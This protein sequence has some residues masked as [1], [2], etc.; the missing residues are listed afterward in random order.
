MFIDASKFPAGHVERARICIF[1]SGPAGMTLA[2]SLAK[3]EIDVLLVEAGGLEFE[4]ESQALYE[5]TVIGDEYYDLDFARLRYFGGTSGHWA[6]YCRPLDAHDFEENP[7]VPHTGWPIGRDALDPYL[8]GAAEILEIPNDFDDRELSGNLD[9]TVFHVSPPVLFGEKYLDE[10]QTSETLRVVL[11]TAVINMTPQGGRVRSA[12]VQTMRGEAWTIEADYFV[13][14]TG[15]IENSRLLLWF[16]EQNDRKLIKNHDILGRYWME[17]PTVSVGEAIIKTEDDDIFDDGQAYF[18]L[19]G[20]FQKVHGV[21]NAGF[22]LEPQAYK[23]RNELAADL[24][25]LA[26]KLS[27][28]VLG[29]ERNLVCGARIEVQ[30]EQAPDP[31]NRV[32]L[33][34]EKDALGIPRV[35]L[36]WRK[37]ALDRKTVAASTIALAEEFAK[38][39]I[40][41][42]RLFDWIDDDNLPIPIA[43]GRWMAAFHHMGGTRMSTTPASGVIDT[44]L[45]VHDLDNLYVGGSS[46]FPSVGYANP[47]LTI[48]QL[49]LRLADHL[50]GRLR[51]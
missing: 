20:A 43:A 26:P 49:S 44:D 9:R 37:S 4:A 36:Y 35:V 30:W 34:E 2:Q 7:A 15:G 27:Q 12:T 28:W 22:N 6:G 8:K 48:V 45:R 19:S 32:A 21:L 40:G 24:F 25:C 50:R 47:T 42:I 41:R 5:G 33:G 13:L 17:R 31:E 10:A 51:G 18:A 3:D 14:C 11:N 1:G 46:V 39:D 29:E 38:L 16:N 23:G